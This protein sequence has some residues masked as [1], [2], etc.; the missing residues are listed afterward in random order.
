LLSRLTISKKSNP[1]DKPS[2]TVNGI[3]VVGDVGVT[4]EVIHIGDEAMFEAL[5]TELRS[6]G[7]D[8][9]VGISN[10]PAETAMRYGIEAIGRIMRQGNREQLAERMTRVLAA[11]GG[12]SSQLAP[13]D[14]AWS[15]IRAI[16]DSDGV[17]IA[18]GGNL[19][20]TWPA[21]VYERA[22]VGELARR[23]NKPLVVTGQTIGPTLLSGDATLVAELLASARLVGVRERS[24]FALASSWG[25]CGVEQNVDDAS[26][27]GT[28]V[29]QS[30]C[31][32]VTLSTHLGPVQRTVFVDRVVE[33][34]DSL[35]LE[36][37]FLAHH[38]SADPAVVRGDSVMHELVRERTGGTVIT[39]TTAR[40]AAATARGA[41]LAVTS[42]Y[43]PAVFAAAAGVPV[44]GIPVDEY[45]GVK[46]GGALGNAGQNG[47]LSLDRLL[48]GEGPS[49]VRAARERPTTA[50]DRVRYDA[51]WDRVAEVFRS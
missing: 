22:T 15:V 21:H 37:A 1:I 16:A 41:A 51:W 24:S 11:A 2:P 5:V 7:V 34:L 10:N 39:A 13:E 32:L 45:T 42:R 25:V 4:D 33:L 44:L 8:R 3:V 28:E 9:F 27:L 36:L 20:S 31:C 23:A 29:L 19:T 47:I 35:D 48:A 18:G 14:S 26:F 17:A 40:A 46:L 12:D 38:G 30:G 50:I 43:H 49:A 6:R